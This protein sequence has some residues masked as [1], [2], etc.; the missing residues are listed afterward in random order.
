MA[1][2]IQGETSKARSNTGKAHRQD[3]FRQP[4][5]PAYPLPEQVEE[6]EPLWS[7]YS[8]EKPADAFFDDAAANRACA[9]VERLYQFEG[10]FAGHRVRL[11]HWQR[12]LLREA[13]GWHIRTPE[14]FVV[15]LYRK[16]YLEVPRKNGKS[17][18]SAAVALY[19]AFEDGEPAPQV[20]FAASDKDQ[21]SIAYGMA[22]A[23]IETDPVMA[24]LS[25]I[26]NS[27]KKIIIDATHGELRCLSSETKK[28]YG[29]NLHGLVFDE[30]MA[31]S[32]R[33][34]WDALTTAQGSRMQPMIFAITTAGWDR[35]SVA[36]E[37]HEYTKQIAEGAFSD[38]AFLGVCYSAPD[39]AD[40]SQEDVWRAAAP[41]LGE[42]VSI[43]YYRTKAKEAQGQPSA[44]NSYC[45]LM[46]CQWVGQSN[47][48]IPMSD[49]DAS[50][51]R[52]VPEL[53]GRRCFGGIDM[54]STTDLTAFVLDFPDTPEDG[55]H[56]WLVRAFTPENKLRERGLRA[57]APYELWVERGLLE[58]VP[59]SVIRDDYVRSAV[60]DAAEEYDL[61]DVTYDRWGMAQLARQLEEEDGIEMWKLGQ[62]FA[63]MSA[64]T[65]ELVRLVVGGKLLGGGHAVL[66]W[67]A[68]GA[69]GAEDPAGNLKFD[70]AHSA[71]KIDLLVAGTMAL[72]GALRRGRKKLVSVYNTRG[73]DD[74]LA[75]LG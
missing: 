10:R 14:G 46:L 64:P 5:V 8:Q 60:R 40:W 49:W 48:I 63:S 19:L 50:A 16:I 17:T 37:H 43:D 1:G 71:A 69:A 51:L 24:D 22:R 55:D 27:T 33:V 9:F 35:N 67:C 53:A 39:N 42:T 73:P 7:T 23:M 45:T 2:S 13:F 61:A 62:G 47:R 21:A 11:M 29:L 44:Q 36:Y 52:E 41:S 32:N 4:P 68:D 59:G 58:M 15:R 38:P 20:F 74:W 65:K 70:K 25:I 72:D 31:Q 56:T 54:S 6:V 28:L 57:R 34:L 75:D 26:Y 3:N 66:R 12:R 18:F 30:L